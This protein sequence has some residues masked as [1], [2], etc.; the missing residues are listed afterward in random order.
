MSWLPIFVILSSVDLSKSKKPS[1]FG[2][3]NLEF[4]G[5]EGNLLY[6]TAT[7]SL[8]VMEL[9]QIGAKYLWI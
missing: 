7:S 1:T 5:N 6:V 4:G 9:N 8:Y 2:Q 3:G